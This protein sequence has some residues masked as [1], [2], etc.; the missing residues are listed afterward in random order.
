MLCPSAGS[1]Q[2]FSAF[3]HGRFCC[4]CFTR[5]ERSRRHLLIDRVLIRDRLHGV[6]DIPLVCNEGIVVCRLQRFDFCCI[7]ES[8]AKTEIYSEVTN[9]KPSTPRY[10]RGGSEILFIFTNP[11]GN[12]VPR[13]VFK[14]LTTATFFSG[15]PISPL[16]HTTTVFALLLRVF[17]RP[18]P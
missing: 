7:S 6:I 11:V 10:K 16:S 18:K 14:S 17:H 5:V 13:R 1:L 3:D 8:I 12:F 15:Y 4:C 9:S 2:I